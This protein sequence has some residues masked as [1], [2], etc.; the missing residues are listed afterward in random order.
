MPTAFGASA[1]HTHT[2]TQLHK[3]DKYGW[4]ECALMSDADMAVSATEFVVCV[5]VCVVKRR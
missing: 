4:Y 5:Y 3:T 1:T 2:Y